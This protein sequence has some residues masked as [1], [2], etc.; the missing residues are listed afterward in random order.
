VGVQDGGWRGAERR[1]RVRDGEMKKI[2][3]QRS[4]GSEKSEF[5]LGGLG[6]LGE[7]YS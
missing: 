2:L 5:L 1:P 7:S 6:G 4:P 3:S